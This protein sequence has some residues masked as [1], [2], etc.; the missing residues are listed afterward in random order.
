MDIT[1]ILGQDEIDRARKLAQDKLDMI[2]E[3][4]DT[5]DDDEASDEGGEE[6]GEAVI[7]RD[8]EDPFW[9]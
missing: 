8:E 6:S 5:S 4:G 2:A 7:S 3:F 1:P 9:T